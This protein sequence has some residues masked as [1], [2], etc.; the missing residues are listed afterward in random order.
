M[1]GLLLIMACASAVGGCAKPK[2]PFS[3]DQFLAAKEKCRAPDAFIIDVAPNMI[4]FRGTSDD[5]VEQAKCFKVELAGTDVETVVLGSQL[6]E[7]P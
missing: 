3:H 7:R 4:G 6:H 1:R 5:H 2:P